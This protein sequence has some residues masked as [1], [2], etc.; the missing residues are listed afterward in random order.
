MS[1][2]IWHL[3]FWIMRAFLIVFIWMCVRRYRLA[4]AS[5]SWPVT[6]GKIMESASQY[7]VNPSAVNGYVPDIRYC[8]TV[9]E[10][11]YESDRL[12]FSL[13][14][15]AGNRRN[16][17]FYVNKYR[18]GNTVNVFFNPKE[19]SQSVLEA[20]IDKAHFWITLILCSVCIGG[21]AFSSHIF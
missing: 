14:Q 15:G 4:Q 17:D 13:N 18:K 16:S 7:N 3:V 19:P 10:I 12:N 5:L 6:S 2:N 8:Y 21:I 20:G 9:N 11:E 1:D